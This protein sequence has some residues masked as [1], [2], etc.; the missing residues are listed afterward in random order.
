MF[1][2]GDS[3]SVCGSRWR[4]ALC[5]SPALRSPTAM[6]RLTIHGGQYIKKDMLQMKTFD[7][8]RFSDAFL[9]VPHFHH[10]GN[11]DT[12]TPSSPVIQPDVRS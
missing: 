7:K 12:N 9:K 1:T 6:T 11:L 3:W 5:L 2:G 4:W 10:A 8:V